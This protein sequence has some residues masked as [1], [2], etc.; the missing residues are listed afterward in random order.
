M[1]C[2]KVGESGTRW[3]GSNQGLG[4]LGQEGVLCSTC[5]RKTVGRAL[6]HHPGYFW[7]NTMAEV[8][9]GN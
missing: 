3:G 1:E 9:I 4:H 2:L 7:K 5:D 8:L 6:H